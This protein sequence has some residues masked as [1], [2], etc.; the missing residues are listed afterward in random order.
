LR[1]PQL[2]RR[3]GDQLSVRAG[4]VLAM[5]GLTVAMCLFVLAYFPNQVAS[6]SR[7]ASEQAAGLLVHIAHQAVE[8][9]FEFDDAAFMDE[10]LEALHPHED[11]DYIAVISDSGDVLARLHEGGVPSLP[12]AVQ[13][14]TTR[15]NH[16][17]H[18]Q[19][20]LTARDGRTATVQLGLSERHLELRD[21][22]NLATSTLVM[23]IA[24]MVSALLSALVARSLIGPLEVMAV[25]AGHLT[26]SQWTAAEALLPVHTP[27]K[28]R[29][30]GRALGRSLR[31]MSEAM[32][33]QQERTRHYSEDLERQVTRQTAE[34]RDALAVAE[35]A[36]RTKSL[37]LAN[38]RHE[39]R[40]PLSGMLGL[41]ELLVDTDLTHQQLDRLHT[42]HDAGYALLHVINDILD[43]SKLEA[44]KL[45]IEHAP[46]N[47]GAMLLTVAELM[48]HSAERD[49][50]SLDLLLDPSLPSGVLG[51]AFR[52]RQIVL[53]L[54]S[55]AIKFT[56][57]G[58]ISLAAH[59]RDL[60]GGRCEVV[61]EVSD[62]GM[63]IPPE[64]LD[65]LFISFNQV[66][67]ST[68][69][70]FGDTGLGL[71]VSRELARLMGGDVTVESEVGVGSTFR[72]VL[73]TETC[74]APARARENA[75]RDA[76]KLSGTVLVVEDNPVNQ[77]VAREMLER[78][79]LQVDVADNGQQAVDK[80]AKSDFDIVFMDCQ[81]PVMDG[82]EASR[83]IRATGS[84]VPIIALTADLLDTRRA[85]CQQAGMNG[86]LGKPIDSALLE[87]MVRTMLAVYANATRSLSPQDETM[88]HEPA[89]PVAL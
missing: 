12:A 75:A 70:R 18:V 14:T 54:L 74:A 5:V 24:L 72:V 81:M 34:L 45:N 84:T 13:L 87:Q 63:G 27:E 59:G 52:V 89:G 83:C 62:T 35:E 77:I 15:L 46:Y 1:E 66:D 6:Q 36:T 41:V 9:G 39:I 56:T 53:N 71:S 25:A 57:E 23:A 88:R 61:L 16:A 33:D 55:N 17:M 80:V 47:P 85:Q 20:P 67:N 28:T 37:F 4:L 79:G 8:P 19:L 42:I 32:R 78:L 43:F 26:K 50:L 31:I 3:L 64:G 22:Q 29:H 44:Q 69:R 48:R 21:T 65:R 73:P 2:W 76:P 40:T 82:L 7:H 11:I 86:F 51:D 10:S 38:M 58:R 30:E 60:G 49:G 68:T